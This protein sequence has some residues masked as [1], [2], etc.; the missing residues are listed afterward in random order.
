[1][2]VSTQL[3]FAIAAFLILVAETITGAVRRFDEVTL[4]G[5]CPECKGKI[6]IKFALSGI[7]PYAFG[8]E[9][10]KQTESGK[11][12]SL[13]D[14]WMRELVINPNVSRNG[15]L[16]GVYIALRLSAKRPFTYPA[17]KTMAKE[18]G[19]SVRQVARALSE[20]E[21]EEFLHVNRN[22]G[23]TSSYSLH[24]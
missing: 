23:H 4:L 2:T 21:D 19:V 6:P 5:K 16:A 8:M 22:A 9:Q 24:L 11:W 12:L 17:M 20:L 14:R 15:K 7:I 3:Q 18:L 10:K 1:L 13:R